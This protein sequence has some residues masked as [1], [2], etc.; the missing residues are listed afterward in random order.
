ML[1]RAWIW[2][3][4]WNFLPICGKIE[5]VAPCAAAQGKEKGKRFMVLQ[6]AG[7]DY[8]T[9]P[10]HLREYSA[11]SVKDSQRLLQTVLQ[12]EGVSGAAL[13]ATCNRTELYL[14]AADSV[15]AAAVFV[16][17]FSALGLPPA[18]CRALESAV[19]VRTGPAVSTYLMEVACGIHSQIFGEDQIVSQVKHA[20]VEAH[21]NGFA[22]PVLERLFQ[23]AVTAAKRVKTECRLT[24]ARTGAASRMVEKLSAREPLKGKTAL[25]IGNGEMGRE[26][27]AA[28]TAAGALVTMTVRHY[29]TREVVIPAGCQVIDY[30]ERYEFL[31]RAEVVVS[32]TRSPH[33]TLSWELLQPLLNAAHP[34]SFVDLAVP[35]DL[36]SQLADAA[37]HRYE[38]MDTLGTTGPDDRQQQ[39][40]LQAKAILAEEQGEFDTWCLT[41]RFA[42]LI[43]RIADRAADDL[44]GRLEKPLRRYASAPDALRDAVWTASE[45]AVAAILYRAQKQLEPQQWRAMLEAMAEEEEV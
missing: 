31:P 2:E 34:Q 14:H 5:G 32:A 16:Q 13:L 28:L 38:N 12:Q 8:Q 4:W 3:L 40:L 9:V 27:A 44:T 39:L 29:K 1:P 42:P 41:R 45:K 18:L 19:T 23:A 7:I 6:M 30:T 37:P 36:P 43:R 35:R 26:A 10:L 11:C 20:W 22:D 15:S 21:E 33:L 24:G 17:A 25:V